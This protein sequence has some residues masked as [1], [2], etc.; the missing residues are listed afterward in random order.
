MAASIGA[1]FKDYIARRQRE[2][3]LR[4]CE[5]S[6]V[7]FSLAGIAQFYAS[8][9]YIH[10]RGELNMADEQMVDNFLLI[11]MGGLRTPKNG[12]KSHEVE[13]S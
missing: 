13:Q 5:P 2:G 12:G 4:Q 10:K 7:L 9:K 1:Q 8:Q 11:L 3:A 6:A